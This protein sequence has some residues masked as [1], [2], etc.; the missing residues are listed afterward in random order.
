MYTVLYS[1]ACDRFHS[2]GGEGRPPLPLVY[3]LMARI[4]V[5]DTV[6]RSSPDPM[7]RARLSIDRGTQRHRTYHKNVFDRFVVI[8]LT[9]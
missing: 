8:L 9:P 2:Y 4:Y 1:R 3:N 6:L 7:K 5:L